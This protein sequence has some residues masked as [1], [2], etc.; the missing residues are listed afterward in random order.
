MRLS[1]GVCVVRVAA[2][3]NK[4]EKKQSQRWR[5]EWRCRDEAAPAVS[6]WE[7]PCNRRIGPR[8]KADEI[9]DSAWRSQ[10]DPWGGG[11]R[12][13]LG[14]FISP[15]YVAYEYVAVRASSTASEQV[16]LVGR[17]SCGYEGQQSSERTEGRRWCCPARKHETQ[18]LSCLLY[19]SD[20]ADE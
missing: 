17:F 7:E 9:L 3:R 16:S 1:R 6:V 10:E 13:R 4:L 15:L 18:T 2:A 14:I 8:Y 11:Q 19:T 5:A 20:A 12:R